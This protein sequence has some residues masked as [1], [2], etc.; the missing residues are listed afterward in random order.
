MS[1]CD[2]QTQHVVPCVTKTYIRHKLSVLC[3]CSMGVFF[4]I[5][6]HLAVLSSV[7]LACQVQSVLLNARGTHE[8][9]LQLYV[10]V[11]KAS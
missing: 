7:P 8:G 9:V 10:E 4:Q 6:F 1:L 11:I 3:I 5:H 2:V